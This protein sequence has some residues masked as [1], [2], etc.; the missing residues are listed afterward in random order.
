M[1]MGGP[2]YQEA[3]QLLLD[4]GLFTSV[5]LDH[6]HIFHTFETS[7]SGTFLTLVR[8]VSQAHFSYLWD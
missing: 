3:P 5:R 4:S 2:R 6:W 7:L 1:L 8:L